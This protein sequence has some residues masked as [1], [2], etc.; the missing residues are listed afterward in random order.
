MLFERILLHLAVSLQTVHHML[1]IEIYSAPHHRSMS[2]VS[3]DQISQS[4]I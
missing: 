4:W 1:S 3:W 2:L